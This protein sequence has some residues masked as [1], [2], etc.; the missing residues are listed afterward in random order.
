MNG[1]YAKFAVGLSLFL[2][3]GLGSAFYAQQPPATRE[4]AEVRLEY[5][6]TQLAL[7]KVEF[8]EANDSNTHVPGTISLVTLNRL[9]GNVTAAEELVA[10]AQEYRSGDIAS[11]QLCYAQ[12][13]AR[14]AELDYSLAKQQR[15]RSPE[16]I[17]RY[18][19]ERL[20]LTAE[21][22]RLRLEMWQEPKHIPSLI[23]EMQ[24][25]IDR[26]GEEVLDLHRRLERLE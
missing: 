2:V 8:E 22:T 23:D 20:R 4:P 17:T 15:Q 25:Q 10:L 3:L 19:L 5:A 24:W 11:T 26:L 21:L 14:V 16:S 13:K 7:A 18:R 12:S 1:S 9:R 6:R